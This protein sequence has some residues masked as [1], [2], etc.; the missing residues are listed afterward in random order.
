MQHFFIKGA[1]LVFFALFAVLILLPQ[2]QA[3]ALTIGPTK[4][5]LQADPNQMLTE[6][7]FL[8]NETDKPLELRSRI[9][10]ITFGPGDRGVPIPA[11]I[12]GD[13]SLA[14][15]ITL[16]DDIVTLAPKEKKEVTLAIRVPAYAYS[17]GY[18]AQV[19]WGPTQS[20]TAGVKAI[21]E[22]GS[23]V[24]LRVNGPVQEEAAVVYFGSED[25]RTQF[26]KLPATFVT[27]IQNNGSAHI[28]PQGRLKIIDARERV[29]AEYEM[30][31]GKEASAILP[32]GDTRRF[33]TVWDS[34]F[35]FGDY[36]AVL[37]LTYGEGNA[38][39]LHAE[40]AFRVM[41]LAIIAIWFLIAV[42][43]IILCV[44]LLRNALPVKGTK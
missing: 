4:M 21:G 19:L 22:V 38:K 14:E 32:G 25:G 23:L 36:T 31:T 11:G 16:S 30:N 5:L 44:R 1:S 2:D 42:I 37:D 43:L 17:G 24:L 35:V 39:N 18:Y 7:L 27:K 10:N 13:M 12:Q 28:I 33:D 9:Q 41:P 6:K 8:L 26:E 40:F 15:W 29:V 3:F 34:G 20:P